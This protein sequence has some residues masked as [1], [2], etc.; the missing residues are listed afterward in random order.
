M[1]HTYTWDKLAKNSARLN[2]NSRGSKYPYTPKFER[3]LIL[4]FAGTKTC[5]VKLQAWGVTQNNLHQ[6]TLLFSDCDIKVGEQENISLWEYFKVEYKNEIYYVKKFD[7]LRNPLTHRCTCFTADTKILLAD[8]T[9]KSFKELEGKEFDVISYNEQVDRFEIVHAFNCNK[10]KSSAELL[11]IT[12]DN[13]KTIDCTPDHRFL[14]RQGD[15]LRADQLSTGVSL[16]AFYGKLNGDK[17]LRYL[18]DNHKQ[19]VTKHKP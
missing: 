12:L 13:G 17:L 1:A 10:K 16:R 18:P 19:T 14:T 3:I 5:L 4:P 9:Q 15:W 11:R 2:P 6:V 8:G 7:R